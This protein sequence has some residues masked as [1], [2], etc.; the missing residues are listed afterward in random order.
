AALIELME[1]EGVT[2]ILAENTNSPELAEELASQTGATVVDDL[3][4][5][6]LGAPGSGAETYLGL[7]RTDTARIVAALA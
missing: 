7:M 4:T 2:V 1:R 6:S 5:D 3:Y